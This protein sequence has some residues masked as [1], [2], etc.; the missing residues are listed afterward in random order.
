MKKLLIAGLAAGLLASSFVSPAT[1]GKK[2]ARPVATTLFLHG[3]EKFGE[4]E[5]FSLL[6][7]A[8]L[9]MDTK[10]PAGSDTKSKGIT[11]YGI[12]PNTRCAGNTLFP[13][14]IGDLRGKVT[15]D[16]K[17][18]LNTLAS[19]GAA[20]EVRIWPDVASLACDSA[21]GNEYI[22]P[23]GSVVVPL[24]PGQGKVEAVIEGVDFTAVSGL[25]LQVS[26]ATIDVNGTPRPLPPFFGR[27]LYDSEAA[28]SSISFSC[29]PSSGKTCA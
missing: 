28:P 16:V 24:P 14:Y 29:T 17:V 21:T 5:S 23:A 27:L 19:P 22:E 3:T 4:M 8:Y 7:D 13:T 25:M 12:G 15:G 2:K 1:A 11:N 6:A 9:K 20:V 10:A 18:S 26:P